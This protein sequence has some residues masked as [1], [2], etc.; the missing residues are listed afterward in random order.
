MTDTTRTGPERGPR[1]LGVH[2]TDSGVDVAVLAPH[3]TAVELC[4]LDGPVDAPTERRVPLSGPQLGIWSASVPGVRPGQRYGLRADGPWEPGQ[5]MRYNPAKLLV[6]PYARGLVGELAYSPPTYGHVVADDLVGNPYGPRDDRDSAGH[7]PHG[8]VVDTRALPGPDPAANRPWTPWADTVVYEAHTKGLTHLHP[9]LPPELRGTYA[10]LAHPAVVDHLLSLGVTAL[11]LLPIHAFASEPHLVAKGLT[12]Y[13]GYSTLG[14][15]APHAAYATAAARAAGP[16]AVLAELR[17]TVHALHEAGLE[18]L[19]DVVYNHT[20]EG[21]LA[22]QHVS[23][24]GLDSAYYYMHDGSVPATLVDVTGTGNSLDFRRTGVVA[25]T[26]DSLRYWADVVGVDGFRFDLAVTLGRST[27]GFRPDHATLIGAATDPSLTGLKLV[28]E[29]WDV[30][31]GGWRTGQFPAPFGEW[32]D[33]FRNAVRSFW[34]SDPGRAAHGLPGDR[35]RDLA[36]RLAGSADLFGSGTPPLTRGPRASINYV[37]AHDGFTLAD[38]VAYEHKHNAANGEQNRDGSDDNRSWNHGVEGPV[39]RESPA[40]AIAPLRR[41]SVRNLFATLVLAAG[42]PMLTAGDETGR[43]QG[44]NNNA[45]CQDNEISWVRWDLSRWRE[46]LLATARHLL[47][48]RREH[49]ALRAETFYSGAPR[50][51][52]GPPDLGWY[53]ADGVPFDHGRW[54]DAS[55]RTFQMV[56]V[57]PVPADDQVLLVVNGALDAVAVRLADGDTTPWTLAWDSVW[58][59][60]AEVSTAAISG[61]LHQSAGSVTTVEPLSMRVYVRP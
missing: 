24:R 56:R 22:G 28:A 48:L 46:D 18:V 14:F 1:R 37:T 57:A 45:Y 50:V 47:A 53:G 36:T 13:W 34:L 38:L 16:A 59:H 23:W 43:S 31:P 5:G 3:A 21:G 44:G 61:G 27:D 25:M 2:V 51:P 15:F 4:L 41:R 19:L 30:G 9:A 7:V 33:R 55:I 54:H 58:E 39:Q 20:C 26:L 12:N 17:A 6:D 11:E 52:G 32:N 10:G 8:V 42:T 35:V 49:P 29:P 60:P 40:A